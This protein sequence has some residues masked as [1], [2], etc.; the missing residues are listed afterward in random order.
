MN[1]PFALTREY[2]RAVAGRFKDDARVSCWQLYNEPLG[3]TEGY[4]TGAAD[5]NVNRLMGWTRE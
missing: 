2:V 4:R 3:H 1:A 5:A